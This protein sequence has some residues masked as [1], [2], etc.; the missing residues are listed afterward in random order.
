MRS[1]NECHKFS[2]VYRYSSNEWVRDALLQVGDVQIGIVWPPVDVVETPVWCFWR[3]NAYNG[4]CM[5]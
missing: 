5:D 3:T 2:V 1:R 4:G